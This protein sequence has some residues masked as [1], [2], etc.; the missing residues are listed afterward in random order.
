MKASSECRSDSHDRAADLRVEAV[1]G[2]VRD[3]VNFS[4]APVHV[5]RL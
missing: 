5:K 3:G 2:S 4:D 1:S